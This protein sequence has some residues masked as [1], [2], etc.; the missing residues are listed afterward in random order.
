MGDAADILLKQLEIENARELHIENQRAAMTNMILVIA[1]AAFGF[2]AQ[3]GLGHRALVVTIPLIGLGL[4]GALASGKFYE[5]FQLHASRAHKLRLRL[6]ELTPGMGLQNTIG[7][8]SA[9]SRAHHKILSR[10]RLHI[11][12]RT[13]H[14]SIA[15]AGMAL[16]IAALTQ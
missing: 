7:G 11:L 8:G 15:A 12:W 2:I 6:D 16:T 3:K 1:A 4:Y 10:V 13:L 5:R 14:L 9:W